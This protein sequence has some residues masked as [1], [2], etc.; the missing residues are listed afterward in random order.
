MDAAGWLAVGRPLCT[1]MRRTDYCKRML[2]CRYGKTDPIYKRFSLFA[3]EL[4]TMFICL[5]KIMEASNVGIASSE[6]FYNNSD[7]VAPP[8]DLDILYPLPKTLTDDETVFLKELLAD[9]RAYVDG[10]DTYPF[11]YHAQLRVYRNAVLNKIIY[12]SSIY[13]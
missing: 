9:T 10:L 8:D 12:S 4:N 11:G 7:W 2:Q 5:G 3:R 6:V 1:L 13:M